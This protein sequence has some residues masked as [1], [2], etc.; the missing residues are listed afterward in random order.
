MKR[1]L[2]QEPFI[3]QLVA[4]LATDKAEENETPQ[5]TAGSVALLMAA[6]GVGALIYG[7]ISGVIPW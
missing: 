3:F 2:G 6:A 7:T 4:L 5:F 1:T